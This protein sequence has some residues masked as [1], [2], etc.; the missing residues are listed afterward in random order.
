MN[1]LHITI[2]HQMVCLTIE[3]LYV[4]FRCAISLSVYVSLTVNLLYANVI[5]RANSSRRLNEYIH[6]SLSFFIYFSHSFSPFLV[7][8][9]ET[10]Y[11][12]WIDIKCAFHAYIPL[13]LIQKVVRKKKSSNRK[14]LVN[15][16][17]FLTLPPTIHHSYSVWIDDFK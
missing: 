12:V 4:R 16:R 13:I 17:A 8:K 3:E 10:L 14:S 1:I 2:S 11:T 9:T 6:F 7:L 15:L 5:W